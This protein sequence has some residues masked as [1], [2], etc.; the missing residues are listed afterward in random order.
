MSDPSKFQMTPRTVALIGMVF[1]ILCWWKA[2]ELQSTIQGL[3]S[4]MAQAQKRIARATPEALAQRQQEARSL[5]QLR[6]R[7]LASL[8]TNENQH[9]TRARLIYDLR[10]KCDAVPLTCQ[11]RLAD[12]SESLKSMKSG[13]TGADSAPASLDALG[14]GRARAV[15]MTTFKGGELD[16]LLGQFNTD[17]TAQW[18]V[19]G[20][21]IRNNG[22]ELDI[23][24]LVLTS[25][26]PGSQP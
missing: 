9:M 13:Q 10:Q 1:A 11:V 19:N 16:A 7:T 15:V 17:S 26:M 24:R 6:E 5:T 2:D 18:R 25:D 8:R 4:R 22:V 23:E 3:N 21:V 14:V 12:L 20:L